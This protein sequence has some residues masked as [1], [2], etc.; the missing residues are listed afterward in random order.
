MEKEE[1]QYIVVQAGYF[2]NVYS[3]FI[4][5]IPKLETTYIFFSRWVKETVTF[6]P[7]K[8]TQQHKLLRYIISIGV[9][10]DWN[11]QMIVSD[12]FKIAFI[13]F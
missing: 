10:S 2:F 9:F 8:T 5:S 13:Y 4:C 11:I 1:E 6:I 3:N 7:C 12:F